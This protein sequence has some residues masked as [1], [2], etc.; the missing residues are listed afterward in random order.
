MDFSIIEL[1]E[2]H[3]HLLQKRELIEGDPKAI[4][5]VDAQIYQCKQLIDH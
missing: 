3:A 5:K 4:E 1:N 2:M